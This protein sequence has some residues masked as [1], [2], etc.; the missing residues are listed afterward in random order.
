MQAPSWHGYFIF[1]APP[2][3]EPLTCGRALSAVQHASYKAYHDHDL[4]I[5]AHFSVLDNSANIISTPK[6][7]ARAAF[8]SAEKAAA[9]AAGSTLGGGDQ[10]D[11]FEGF[12]SF[13]NSNS[14]GASEMF[15][16]SADHL[17]AN[18][19]RPTL[20]WIPP[21]HEQHDGHAKPSVCFLFSPFQRVLDVG[22]LS[23]QDLQASS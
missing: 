5:C 6:S 23:H 20:Y 14:N 4:R 11:E 3:C 9:G 17:T 12:E 7:D 22:Q 13:E 19:R 21:A 18:A 2:S 10:G 15:A 16:P 8:E 1:K